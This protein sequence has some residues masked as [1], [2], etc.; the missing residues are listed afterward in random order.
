MKF[1]IAGLIL[2]LPMAFLMGYFAGQMEDYLFE[3]EDDEQ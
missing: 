2:M 1:L 3:R